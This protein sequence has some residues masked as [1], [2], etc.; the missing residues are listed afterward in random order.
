MAP[1]W[2]RTDL[3]LLAALGGA[4]SAQEPILACR[5]ASFGGPS[6]KVIFRMCF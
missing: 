6:S 5:E 4:F 1:E 3:E 2:H